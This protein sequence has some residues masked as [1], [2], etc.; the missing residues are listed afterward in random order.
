MKLK[1][2]LSALIV[3]GAAGT[4]SAQDA[5]PAMRRMGQE[6]V[7]TSSFG[8]LT[9]KMLRK[10][11]DMGIDASFDDDGKFE[12]KEVSARDRFEGIWWTPKGE[13]ECATA[14]KG[15]KHWGKMHFKLSEFGRV[16]TGKWGYCDAEPDEDFKAEWQRK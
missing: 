1:L 4:A 9:D 10:D 11:E 6:S 14:Q 13:K 5:D 16:F 3:I 2:A 15:S 12:T 7:R 8:K